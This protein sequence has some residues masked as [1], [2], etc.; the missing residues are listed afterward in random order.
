MRRLILLCLGSVLI[1]WTSFAFVLAR[2]LS[3]GT[4]RLEINEKTARA[5]TLKSPKLVILAG[6]NA[7]FSHSCHVIGTMLDMPCENGGV[8]VGLGLDEIFARWRPLLHR[9]DVVYMPME[10]QQYVMS[11]ASTRMSVDGAMMF[12]HDR[13][14]LFRLGARR[15]LAASFGT[16]MPDALEA[17]AE[18]TFR[19]LGFGH[20][21]AVLAAEYNRQGDRI[22]TTIATADQG[23]LSELHRVE[24]PANA[25][26]QGYGTRLIER[27]VRIAT[28]RGVTVIGGLPTDF[29]R[30]PLPSADVATIRAAYL[31]NGGN[32]IALPNRSRYAQADFWNTE[33]HLAQPCQYLNSIAIARLLASRLHRIARQPTKAMT[34]LAA[35]CPS[36]TRTPRVAATH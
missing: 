23:F 5:A 31:D 12:R 2:P 24:P 21:H 32:F 16:T 8:A 34:A 4:I 6:S 36:A 28:S 29:L 13:R 14:L 17:I 7:P 10:I 20:P 22:G 9:G 33:D 15:V 26:A 19:G 35:A 25:I 18:M 27:F 1:Y 3:L 11:A 30:V